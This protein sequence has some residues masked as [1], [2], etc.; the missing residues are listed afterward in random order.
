MAASDLL[1]T[2]GGFY[3]DIEVAKESNNGTTRQNVRPE[4][5]PDQT[6]VGVVSPTGPSNAS[7]FGM[8]FNSSIL[9][10]TVGVVAAIAALRYI[11]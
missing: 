3:R 7:A 2:L 10:A 5:V 4:S 9:L 1:K 6:S 8:Q 11:R